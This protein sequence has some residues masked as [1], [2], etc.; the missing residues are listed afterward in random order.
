MNFDANSLGARH[1]GRVI[2]DCWQSG[3]TQRPGHGY[4]S[5]A[6][7]LSRRLPDLVYLIAGD[8]PYRGEVEGWRWIWCSTNPGG[9]LPAAWRTSLPAFF[10][11]LCGVAVMARRERLEERM[12]SRALG[13]CCSRRMPV[14]SPSSAAARWAPTLSEDGV[15]GLLVDPR[16]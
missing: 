14:A 9:F 4:S 16:I 3:F 13:L 10:Y 5:L 6:R 8:G 2:P 12:M 7:S 15:S 11:A 1:G